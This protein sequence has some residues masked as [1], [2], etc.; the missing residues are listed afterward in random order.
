MKKSFCDCCKQEI[1]DKNYFS[2][3]GLE[4]VVD[5]KNHMKFT[6]A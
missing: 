6:V 5:K 4:V 2:A 1:D 3:N